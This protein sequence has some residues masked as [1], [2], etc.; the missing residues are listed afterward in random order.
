MRRQ[1][2]ARGSTT[3]GKLPKSQG[4]SLVD[5]S[6]SRADGPI[7]HQKPKARGSVVERCVARY[8]SVGAVCFLRRGVETDA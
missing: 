5:V 1:G 3:R 6:S 2:Q 7:I 8:T 4:D